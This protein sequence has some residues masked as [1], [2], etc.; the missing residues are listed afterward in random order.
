MS[1]D[2]VIYYMHCGRCYEELP[3]GLSA[4]EYAKLEVGVTK[5]NTILVRCIRHDIDLGEFKLLRDI[6]NVSCGACEQ[7]EG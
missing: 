5:E 7:K 4:K 6:T 2:R 3:V 1:E